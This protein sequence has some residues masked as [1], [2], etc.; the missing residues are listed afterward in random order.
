VRLRD[1]VFAPSIGFRMPDDNVKALVVCRLY[2]D[3]L[4]LCRLVSAWHMH[5][6]ARARHNRDPL[7]RSGLN[8]SPLK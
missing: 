2:A 5:Q 3:Y 8:C 6:H 4:V 7:R 1:K